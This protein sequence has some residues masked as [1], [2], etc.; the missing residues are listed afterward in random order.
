MSL[1]SFD[2]AVGLGDVLTR[3]HVLVR[4]DLAGAGVSLAAG[5]TLATLE[6]E[7]P[8]RL[9]EL[10]ALQQV[11]QPSMSALIARLE[12]QQLVERST[13]AADGRLVIVSITERGRSVL[14][15]IMERRSRLLAGH[16]Q[17]VSERDREAVKRAL[18]ALERLV[19]IMEDRVPV[20]GQP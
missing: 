7:G 14:T 9:T 12:S 19:E 20:G 2:V 13:N 8:K 4:R 18:P 1:D 11:A 10:A 3:L 17:G 6:R 16:L 5:R 15:S